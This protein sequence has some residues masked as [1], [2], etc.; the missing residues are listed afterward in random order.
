MPL[1]AAFLWFAT[2]FQT[3][4]LLGETLLLPGPFPIAPLATD[5]N[6]VASVG[7]IPGGAGPL[8]LF[9]HA[10][11]IDPAQPAG[12]AVANAVAVLFP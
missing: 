10:A 6:G 8:T 9:T 11:V 3:F 5:V 7:P 2:A 4:T 12:L 1:G